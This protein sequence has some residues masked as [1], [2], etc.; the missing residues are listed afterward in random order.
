[1]DLADRE[2]GYVFHPARLAS[3]S[4]DQL[5]ANR[6]SPSASPG[7]SILEDSLASA[8]H[9]VLASPGVTILEAI[10]DDW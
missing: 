2:A 7:A 3:S 10:V 9:I 1:M 8:V 5:L 6:R 4:T